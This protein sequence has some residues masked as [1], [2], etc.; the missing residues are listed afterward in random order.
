MVTK[1]V[2]KVSKKLEQI[3][4]EVLLTKAVNWDND[5]IN[6]KQNEIWISQIINVYDSCLPHLVAAYTQLGIKDQVLLK[7]LAMVCLW[8]SNDVT[9]YKK[10]GL[11]LEMHKKNCFCM[12]QL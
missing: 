6:A 5:I 1:C 11:F 3:I 2:V 4:Y 7:V 10:S 8:E 12:Q 9:V